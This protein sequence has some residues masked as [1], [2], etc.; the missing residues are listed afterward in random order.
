MSSS[1]SRFLDSGSKHHSYCRK[2]KSLGV[3]C[4]NFVSLYDRDGVELVGLDYAARQ[5]G[6]ERRRIYDIVN[7]MES[8]GVLAR[9]AKNKYSWI[10]FSG[11]PKALKEL[12]EEALRAISGSDGPCEKEVLEDEDDDS[13][14]QNH[15]DGDEKFSKMDNASSSGNHLCKARSASDN[16]KEK[17]LGLLTRN[18]VKL[19]L[20]SDVDTISL[21]EAAR[22]LLGDISDLSNMRS[23]NA[24]KVR[25]LYDIANVLSSMNL[26]E[27]I[28]VE[29]RKPAFR[30]LGTEG[31]TKTDTVSKKPGK[32]QMRSDDLKECNLTAQKQLSTKSGYAFGPFCPAGMTKVDGDVEGKGER[33]TQ[34]WESLACSLRPQYH[35]QALNELFTHYMEAWKSWYAELAQGSYNL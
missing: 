13:E 18:F 34:D 9:K 27:K 11:I 21:D 5:L 10:G 29:A 28:Q 32:A 3:L 15:D 1:P 17:S 23:Y 4:S 25:R 2:Q 14:G 20:T 35:N 24:A 31:K 26:I 19:F 30:W 12:K 22:L 6:V 33:S 16:R 8:V 7:V